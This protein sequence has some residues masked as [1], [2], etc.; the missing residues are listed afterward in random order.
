MH[1]QIDAVEASLHGR[2]GGLQNRIDAVEAS[3]HGRIG[4]VEASL[5]GR[6]DAVEASLHDRIDAVKAALS[7][8]I[9]ESEARSRE[10]TEVIETR[11]L[12][13][14][15]KWAKTAEVRYRNGQF[16]VTGMEERIRMVEERVTELESRSRP[17]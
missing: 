17:S 3:L 15:W 13:E 1:G 9:A 2:I 11:L 4:A 10:H 8:Q 6:I 5:H 14:F 12:S 7:T 16:A